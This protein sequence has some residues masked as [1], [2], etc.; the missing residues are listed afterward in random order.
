M[1]STAVM[2][3][4]RTS[5]AVAGTEIPGALATADSATDLLRIAVE[6]GANV[7]QLRELV[8][9]HELMTEREAR[10]L[11]SAALVA[12]Q[13][14]CPQIRRTETASIA[15]KSG[16]DFKF[17]FAD[18]TEIAR[19]INPVLAKHGLSYTWDTEATADSRKI[20]CTIHHE[21][22]ASRSSSVT[23][24]VGNESRMSPQQQVSAAQAYGERLSL[25]AVLGLTTTDANAEAEAEADPTTVT[26][27]QATQISDLLKTLSPDKAAADK[28]RGQFLKY[29]GVE[30]VSEIRRADYTRAVQM[31]ERKRAS[32]SEKEGAQ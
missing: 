7:E 30:A 15:T 5:S 16:R 21:A 4:P 1:D 31:L 13:R 29:L 22:G 27:D 14:D 9:L 2:P 19:T 32:L 6:K 17:T 11:F 24:P 25:C 20:T 8:E 26:D 28:L 18:L 3:A 23:M 12:F 10:R